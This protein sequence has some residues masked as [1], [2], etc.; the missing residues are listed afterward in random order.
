MI[1]IL[2]SPFFFAIILSYLPDDSPQP[3]QTRRVL[4]TPI[5]L[6]WQRSSNYSKILV[7]TPAPTVRPPS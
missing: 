6:F 7:M 3:C 1:M 2:A 5:P 4:G